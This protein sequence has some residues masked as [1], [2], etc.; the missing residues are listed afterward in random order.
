MA[1]QAPGGKIGDENCREDTPVLAASRPEF[2][3]FGR[4]I[5]AWGHKTG[6]AAMADILIARAREGRRRALAGL[7]RGAR[8]LAMLDDRARPPR[9]TISAAQRFMAA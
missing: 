9:L 7:G 3:A 1:A 2:A 6:A 4:K 5:S 8:G